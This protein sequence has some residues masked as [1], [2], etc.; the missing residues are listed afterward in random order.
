MSDQLTI[1]LSDHAANWVQW[2]AQ[3]TGRSTSQVIDEAV[4]R[5][6]SQIAGES[7]DFSRWSDEEILAAA[8]GSMPSSLA[9][10]R[11]ELRQKQQQTTLDE[12]EAKELESIRQLCRVEDLRK[13]Q[14]MVEAVRRGLM[15]R[16]P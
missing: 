9:N 10:R 2:Y 3:M 1:T 15:G 4:E 7:T 5:S 14:A 13:A 11:E 6:R 16:A 8:N 12:V